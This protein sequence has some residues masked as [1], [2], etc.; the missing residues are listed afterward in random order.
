MADNTMLDLDVS[1]DQQD[2]LQSSNHEEKLRAWN[3]WGERSEAVLAEWQ[4]LRPY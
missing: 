4:R 2:A 1:K 3:A